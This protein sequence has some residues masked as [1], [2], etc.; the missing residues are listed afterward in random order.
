MNV[1]HLIL[2]LL[3]AVDEGPGLWTAVNAA[4]AGRNIQL[5]EENAMQTINERAASLPSA[6]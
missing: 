2:S 6:F 4:A 1:R 5:T 3:D